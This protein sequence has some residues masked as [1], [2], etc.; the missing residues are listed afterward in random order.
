MEG[1]HGGVPWWG[2]MV[3]SHGGVT[4]IV[5]AQE[6][7]VSTKQVH[8]KEIERVQPVSLTVSY[9]LPPCSRPRA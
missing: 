3:G 8:T 4:W 1:R 6:E 2:P 9:D 7:L 5:G